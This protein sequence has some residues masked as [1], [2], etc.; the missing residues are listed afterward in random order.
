M[1]ESTKAVT[2]ANTEA[3]TTASLVL[4][5]KRR[6]DT[7]QENLTKAALLAPCDGVLVHAHLVPS[8]Q[9]SVMA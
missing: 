6:L 9:P 1:P 2:L 4:Q 7:A 3:D 5:A 8:Q